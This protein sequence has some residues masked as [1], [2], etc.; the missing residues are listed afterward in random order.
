MYSRIKLFFSEDVYFYT[1]LIVLVSLISF[2]LGRAS[3]Q[4][5]VIDRTVSQ[6]RIQLREPIATA[7]ATSPTIRYVGSKNGSKYH[8]PWCPGASQ[9]KEANRIYF[10]SEEEAQVR[11]YTPAANCKFAR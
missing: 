1:V 8:A 4:S 2:A 7:S 9:I 3:V 6:T 11:G 10:N 5:A